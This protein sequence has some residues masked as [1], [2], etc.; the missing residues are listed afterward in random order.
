MG[1]R[2]MR[3]KSSD[4]EDLEDLRIGEIA[5]NIQEKYK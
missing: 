2:I 4:F 3:M 5:A 1:K